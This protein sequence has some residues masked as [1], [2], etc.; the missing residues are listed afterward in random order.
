MKLDTHIQD[1]IR[2][3]DRHIKMLWLAV[4]VWNVLGLTW[5]HSIPFRLW[6]LDE[7]GRSKLWDI[8]GAAFAGM[9]GIALTSLAIYTRR[10]I[11]R[12]AE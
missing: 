3:Q 4:I 7:P 6:M 8:A 12:R 10:R 11:R 1:E 5:S 9:G 2:R